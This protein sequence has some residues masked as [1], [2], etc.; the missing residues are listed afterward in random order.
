MRMEEF[1]SRQAKE[2]LKQE[3][4]EYFF[5]VFSGLISLDEFELK[6]YENPSWENYLGA[7]LYMD[8]IETNYVRLKSEHKHSNEDCR[9][10]GSLISFLE[11]SINA[12]EY[13]LW[14][15]AKAEEYRNNAGKTKPVLFLSELML[16]LPGNIEGRK[17]KLQE[18]MQFG[19]EPFLFYSAPLGQKEIF[20]AAYADDL[21]TMN[22][23]FRLLE[24][25]LA[26]NDP[27]IENLI[28]IGIFEAIQ[29]LG[30][31]R[32]NG[33]EIMKFLNML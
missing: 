12:Y 23:Y 17:S 26:E 8:L 11:K 29:N 1:M 7:D 30:T 25:M 4:S 22:E 15:S 5:Q 32:N 16:T 13:L 3:W 24:D 21:S 28:V 2:K 9:P 19:P 14:H 27:N 31:H 10:L 18:C 20:E 33:K 6:L